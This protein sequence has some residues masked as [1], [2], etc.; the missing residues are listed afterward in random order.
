MYR[1]LKRIW[2][3]IGSNSE[4]KTQNSE[5]S[6]EAAHMMHKTIKKVTQDIE[7]LS[8]NTMISTIME[9][10]NFLEEKGNNKQKTINRKQPIRFITREEV[11]TL[12]LL[13]ASFAPHITEELWSRLSGKTK[14]DNLW[15]IHTHPWPKYDEK[16]TESSVIEVVVQVNGKL[17]GK[18]NVERD[19]E[20]TKVQKLALEI[21]GVLRHLGSRKP[22]KIVFV[23]NRLINFVV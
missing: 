4:L 5:L 21:A 11:R 3:L 17:R 20:Q 7:S 23:K 9:W 1:F 19:I 22:K 12:L 14:P 2:K 16:L 13:L 10:V 18:L 8:Y 15:S 6:S